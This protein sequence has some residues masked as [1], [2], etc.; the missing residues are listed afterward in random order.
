MC[1]HKFI[2]VYHEIRRRNG[3]IY[4]YIV[5]NIRVKDKWE[6][7]S[8]FVGKGKMSKE[9]VVKAIEDFK[10]EG[11]KYLAKSIYFLIEDIKEKFKNYLKKGGKSGRDKFN[12]WYFT[13]LTYNSNAIEGNSLSLMDTA[14][15]LNE[16]LIPKESSL[17]EV[18]EVKNHK[19]AI[20]FMESYEGDFN[21]RFVLRLHSFILKGI[22]DDNAGK[23]R[24]IQVFI[25]GEDVKFP[26]FKEVPKLIEEMFKWYKENKKVLHAFELAALVSMKFVSIHPFVDGNGR[27]SRL[28][29]NFILKK[30]GYPEINVYFKHRDNYLRAVRKA[31]DEDYLL[32]VDF[33]VKSL[34]LNYKFLEEKD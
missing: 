28:I 11:C 4:N 27:V 8:K 34:K 29:M 7:E 10:A 5:R 2:M 26:N 31:N 33:L 17:R 32:I 16:G 19:K 13:E 23:Y 3:K 14:R 22:D 30:F 25:G 12:E 18:Y 20:E 6:K 1:P 21:E 9:E 24:E 15:I